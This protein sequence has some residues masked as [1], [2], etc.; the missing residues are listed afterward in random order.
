MAFATSTIIAAVGLG[1]TAAG[2]GTQMYAMSQQKEVSKEMAERQ[3]QAEAVRQQQMN[4]ESMRKKREII[5]NANVASS[6]AVSQA[7]NQGGGESSGLAGALASVSGRS[8]G[9]AL[10]VEQNT[11]LGNQMFEINKQSAGLQ[12]DRAGWDS[13]SGIGS[14]ISSLGGS[15]VRHQQQLGSFG[16]WLYS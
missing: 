13:V 9:S 16:T 11:Q 7:T 14:G 12:A 1:L 4:L 2:V 15:M 5:R 3:K 8:G 6:M 10:A